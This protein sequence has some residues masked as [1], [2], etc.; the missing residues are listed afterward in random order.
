MGFFDF[1][2][3]KPSA[4]EPGTRA[5]LVPELMRALDDPDPKVRLRA[6]RQLGELGRAAQA[7]GEKLQ[8]RLNDEDGD[9]CN[10]AAAALSEIE[11]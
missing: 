4:P 7:A 2:K 3:P 1:L 8:D 11:R 6:C 9:V 5:A 10:A